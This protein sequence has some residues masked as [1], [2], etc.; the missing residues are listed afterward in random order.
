MSRKSCVKLKRQRTPQLTASQKTHEPGCNGSFYHCANRGIP[1]GSRRLLRS[2]CR[3]PASNSRVTT[4]STMSSSTIS[5]N[6]Q[7]SSF[8]HTCDVPSAEERIL[9]VPTNLRWIHSP[10]AHREA[11]HSRRYFELF[12]G[13]KTAPH[14][15]DYIQDS[16][17]DTLHP[18]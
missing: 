4:C 7:F 13:L 1:V 15:I 14:Q 2:Q 9:S 3:K 17:L 8:S 16:R 6:L 18:R 11:D 10:V 12:G 5:I